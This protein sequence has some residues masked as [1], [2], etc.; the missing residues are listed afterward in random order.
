MQLPFTQGLGSLHHDESKITT[1]ES[2]DQ[3]Y[4]DTI[5]TNKIQDCT[6]EVKTICWYVNTP[7]GFQNVNH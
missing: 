7:L 2:D 3:R 1:K 6:H 4:K 5:Q